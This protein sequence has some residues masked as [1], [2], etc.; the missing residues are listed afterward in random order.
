MARSTQSTAWEMPLVLE[1][2]VRMQQVLDQVDSR[3]GEPPVAAAVPQKFSRPGIGFVALIALIL[4]QVSVAI[5]ALLACVRMAAP[6][7]AAA[8]LAAVTAAA[9]AFRDSPSELRLLMAT[10][11]GLTGLVL[12]MMA[13]A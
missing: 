6:L 4:G 10:P 13:W 3:L 1:D 11:I 9:L 7:L 12:L 2:V 8:G 5:I